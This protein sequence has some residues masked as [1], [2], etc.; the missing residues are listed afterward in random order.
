VRTRL[1][2]EHLEVAA[3]DI[4]DASPEEVVDERW[5]PIADEQ[6]EG[7]ESGAPATHRLRGLRGVSRRSRRLLGP[8]DGLVTDS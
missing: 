2:A 1:W 4:A 6:L 5:K 8:L 7:Y 3:E